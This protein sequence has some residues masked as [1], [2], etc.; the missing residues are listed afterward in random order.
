[1]N[2]IA[3]L[4]VKAWEN[5]H[6]SAAAIIYAGMKIAAIWFPKYKSQIEATEAI[7]VAYGLFM[8]GDAIAGKPAPVPTPPPPVPPTPPTPPVP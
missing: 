2:P 7:A 6:T 8:A 4:I 3:T 5:K 1:M